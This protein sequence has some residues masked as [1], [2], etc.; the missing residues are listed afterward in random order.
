MASRPPP[1]HVPVTP[2][3]RAAETDDGLPPAAAETDDGPPPP[4]APSSRA[5]DEGPAAAA[6]PLSRASSVF[7]ET[8]AASRAPTDDDRVLA[9]LY[10][11]NCHLQS[12]VMELRQSRARLQRDMEIL[13]ITSGAVRRGSKGRRSSSDAVPA[14]DSADVL[15]PGS[16]KFIDIDV[17]EGGLTPLPAAATRTE[18]DFSHCTE[19]DFSVER[20]SVDTVDY[21][22]CVPLNL[23][24]VVSCWSPFYDG[25]SEDE[26]EYVGGSLDYVGAHASYPK[27]G[28]K[29]RAAQRATSMPSSWFF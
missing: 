8:S 1:V 29:P 27:S 7:S 14:D 17:D 25:D 12:Q 9:A 3:A 4:A 24:P 23:R 13:E 11:A 20:T 26:M 21:S 2:E 19:V 28:A 15:S 18:V 10:E 16:S 22:S 5:S 6:A